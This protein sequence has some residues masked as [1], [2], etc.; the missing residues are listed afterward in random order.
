MRAGLLQ[1]EGEQERAGG[2]VLASPQGRA[3]LGASVCGSAVAFLDVQVVGVAL[4]TIGREL[5][6]GLGVLQWT[7]NA[8]TLAL[9]ALV[10]LGGSLGD[11]FG[12]RRVFTTGVVWFALASLACAVAP[13]AGALVAARAVQGVGAALL[14]PVSLALLQSVL[15]PRDRARAIGLWSGT[16]TLAT[17]AAPVVGGALVAL[18]WRLVFAL[19]VPVAAAAVVLARRVPADRPARVPGPRGRALLSL[20]LGG[21]A[22]GALAL[23]AGTWALITAGGSGASPA[24]LASGAAAV[25][26][27]AVFVLHERRLARR[28]ASPVVPPA[29]FADRT[30]SVANGYTLL[31]YAALSGMG[32]L[33]ALQLQVSLGYSPLQAGL[34][35]LPSSLLLGVLSGRAGQL[36][37]RLGV[38][39]MLTAGAALGACGLALLSGA[40]PGDAYA[41]AVLPGVLVMGLGFS[42]LVAPLTAGV[43]AAAPQELAGAASGVN[44]AVAR[45]AGLLSVA[46]L[47]V[48]V[49]LSGEAYTDPELLTAG[50]RAGMLVCAGLVAAAAVLAGVLLP[51]RAGPTTGGTAPAAGG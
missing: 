30:F 29:L 4:P 16:T 25:V 32:L 43:L 22:L 2:V 8:Y 21:A 23:G 47:P 50:Y 36:G 51:R 42:A 41:A 26:L 24:V 11:R 44:N 27:V 28:G 31:V 19:N 38:R 7:V 5:G 15:R 46:A 39:T 37:Q 13:S 9:A 18:D 12:L 33:L 3:V 49:G 45:T 40:S 1:G 6:A 17:V 48:L 35:S 10:L 20:D 14:T 34:A